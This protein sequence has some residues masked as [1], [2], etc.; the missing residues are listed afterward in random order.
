MWALEKRVPPCT[1]RLQDKLAPRPGCE[2]A[3]GCVGTTV[4]VSHTPLS[5]PTHQQLRL[6]TLSRREKL[7]FMAETLQ[8][9]GTAAAGTDASGGGDS[10]LGGAHR[11]SA[12]P[13][14]SPEGRGPQ[15]GAAQVQGRGSQHGSEFRI[16]RATGPQAPNWLLTKPERC[17]AAKSGS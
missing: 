3:N 14:R 6:K 2:E 7:G 1:W 8:G 10:A 15:A 11:W 5:G 16:P 12:P 13:P 17:S 4:T 9:R